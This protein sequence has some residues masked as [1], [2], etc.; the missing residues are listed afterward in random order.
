VPSREQ[1]LAILDSGCSYAEAGEALQISTGLAYMIA[2]GIPAD[3]SDTVTAEQL[4]RPHTF[5]ATS[6]HL[7]NPP[8]PYHPTRDEE[9]IAWV[10]QRARDDQQMQAAAASADGAK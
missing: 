8:A 6:Q 1:V 9:V 10:K 5:P 3:G 4:A 2:T 7:A